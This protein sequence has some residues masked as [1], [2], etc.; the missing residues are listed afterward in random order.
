M[1]SRPT[2]KA[3]VVLL[4]PVFALL[5]ACGGGSPSASAPAQS[6][7]AVSEAVRPANYT[8]ESTPASADVPAAAAPVGQQDQL[9]AMSVVSTGTTRDPLKQPFATNSIWNMPIGTGAQYVAANLSGNPGN[10]IWALMPGIDGE[11]I[12]LKPTAPM[13]ALNVSSAGWTGNNRCAATGGLQVSV[14]MPSNYVVPNDNK[15]SAG[16]FLMGDKRTIVQT[17]PLARCTAG[18]SGTSMAKF[19]NVD[20]YGTGITGAHGG[21]GLSSIGGSIRIGELRPGST[22]GPLHAL[23]VNVY[24][25]EALYKCTTRANCFRWPATHSDNYAV[26]WYGATNNNQNTAMKMGALLAIPTA[27]TIASLNLETAPAKQLAW[28]LQNYGAYIVDDAY[29]PGFDMSVENGPDGNK[30]AE[31]KADYGFDMAQRVNQNTAWVRD[32]QKLVKALYV[33]NNNTSTSIG[34]GG[35]PRQP[36]APAIAP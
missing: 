10:N 20:L 33:V 26:G 24:A 7:S 5:A 31:F 18:A 28:T 16:V 22:T 13:T 11:H 6:L 4:A 35:T 14:P 8:V 30:Q 19:A 25:K 3:N 27:K 9:L 23:K 34:G 2:P 17:Q 12:I 36:L 29:A 15:N 32:I 21:S 1:T